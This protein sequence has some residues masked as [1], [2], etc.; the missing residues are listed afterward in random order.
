MADPGN[1]FRVDGII[2]QRHNRTPEQLATLNWHDLAEFPA[3]GNPTA[4]AFDGANIWVANRGSDYIN[5]LD[6]DRTM[7]LP[8]P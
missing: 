2:M 7:P 4:I 5:K 1:T 8:R 6:A 3:R